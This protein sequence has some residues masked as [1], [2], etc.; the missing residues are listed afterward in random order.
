M[1]LISLSK[2]VSYD[3]VTVIDHF[4]TLE[5]VLICFGTIEII[6]IIIITIIIILFFTQW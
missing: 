6:M 2:A 1:V 4:G 5:L 3:W